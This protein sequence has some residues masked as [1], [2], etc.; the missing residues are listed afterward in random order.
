[1]QA[2]V[3]ARWADAGEPDGPALMAYLAGVH[4]A[5][6]QPGQPESVRLARRVRAVPRGEAAVVGEERARQADWPVAAASVQIRFAQVSGQEVPKVQ[7][8]PVLA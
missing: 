7:V 3:A 2:D 5:S 4:G 8:W 1:M 6:P